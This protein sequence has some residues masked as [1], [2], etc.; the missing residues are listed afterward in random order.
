MDINQSL[1]RPLSET[2]SSLASYFEQLTSGQLSGQDVFT[3]V[4]NLSV[5]TN[6]TY[7]TIT[8]IC[9][10]VPLLIFIDSLGSKPSPSQRAK[11]E[12]LRKKTS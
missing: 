8:L 9:T 12:A 3:S 5:F 6:P 11:E 10:L 7:I 1:L 4:R 2:Y